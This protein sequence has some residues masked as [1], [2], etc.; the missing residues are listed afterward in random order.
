MLGLVVYALFGL[1]QGCG[2]PCTAKI[3]R[4]TYRPS[5]LGVPWGVMSTAS[6]FAAFLSPFLVSTII[7]NSGNWK[8]CFYI[9]GSIALFLALPIA[10]ITNLSSDHPINTKPRPSH[11]PEQKQ[12]SKV[13][14]F[15]VFL[16]RDLWGVMTIHSMLWLV[17]ASVLDWGQ[18]YLVQESGFDKVSAGKQC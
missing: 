3:L 6:S 13:R 7:T 15:H 17:K 14:W 1:F 18:L 2:W 10:F 4:Q 8:Y 16:V 12:S 9:F 11:T 5:E